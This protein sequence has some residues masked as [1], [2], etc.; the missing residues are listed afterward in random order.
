MSTFSALGYTFVASV[1][2]SDGELYVDDIS[3]IGDDVLHLI[4]PDLR[5]SIEQAAIEQAKKDMD[6]AKAEAAI[7]AYK[8]RISIYG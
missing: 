6:E 3:I 1:S 5:E 2:G 8:E 4:K 7:E